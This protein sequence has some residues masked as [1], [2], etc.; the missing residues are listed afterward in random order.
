MRFS[1]AG[2]DPAHCA[3]RDSAEE[4]AGGGGPGLAT[5]ARNTQGSRFTSQ[6]KQC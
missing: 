5:T 3:T 4:A 6:Q 2:G 1:L